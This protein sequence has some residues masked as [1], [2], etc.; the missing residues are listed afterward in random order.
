MRTRTRTILAGLVLAAA[1]L[2]GAAWATSAT[3]LVGA[4]RTIDGC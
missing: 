2:G 1:L 4:D 3:S